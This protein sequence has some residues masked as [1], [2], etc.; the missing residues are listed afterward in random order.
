MRT[1]WLLYFLGLDMCL[2]FL[3][4][5]ARRDFFYW[6]NFRGIVR[7]VGSLLLRFCT[8]FLVN[9]TMLIQMRHPQ[10]V[11][12]L[13]FLISILYSVV[14]TFGSVHLYA[15]HYDGGNSKIDENTLHL[16][17]GSLFAMWFISILTFAS[18]IKRKYLHTFYDTVTASTYNRDWYL[19]LR[20]DQDDVKSDL[21]LKHPDMYSRWGDQ[22]VMPWTLNNW[23]R[24]EE[25]KPIWFTDSWIE[26][27]PNEYI[28]YD[29]R[30]KYKKTK[31]RVDNPKK[32]RGSVGVTELLVGEEER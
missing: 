2:F 7:L 23:E 31:G 22:H 16:V 6:A 4:K 9:F 27:V 14:G 24:W 25:E 11:G 19:R 15:N 8:K 5:I 1:S 20:E 21:L 32:R 3:Y 17:V 18:V 29:W 12:G 28:P 13:P 26:H 10:E 30:V